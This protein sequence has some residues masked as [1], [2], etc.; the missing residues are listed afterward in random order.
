M[1]DESSLP[2]PS[3]ESTDISPKLLWIGVPSL[4]ATVVALAL[5]VLWLF[6]GRTVDR[7]MHLPLPH[8]PSPE[9]QV[10]PRED[11]ARFLAR[12]LQWLNGTGWI[13]KKHGVAH[14]PIDAAMRE[15]ASE[16][17]ADWPAPVREEHP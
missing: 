9:L 1:A 4:V 15:V 3:H 10:N 13:D 7:T 14:I 2:A 11:M 5:L 17:I 6:P 12:E 8:Y 16:G